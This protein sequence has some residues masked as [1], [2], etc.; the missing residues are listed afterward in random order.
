MGR[1]SL[2]HAQPISGRPSGAR[3]T[4]WPFST[5]NRHYAG[6]TGRGSIAYREDRDLEIGRD[7]PQIDAR[8]DGVLIDLGEFFLIEVQL[9]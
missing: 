6:P 8:I 2:V 7:A 5:G 1:Q 3:H 4:R 9:L